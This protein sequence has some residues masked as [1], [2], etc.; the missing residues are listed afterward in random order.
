M[1]TI[2]SLRRHSYLKTIGTL[3]IA[4]SLIAG[5]VGCGDGVSTRYNLTM[6]ASPVD[7]GNATDETNGSPY[8]EGTC[9]RIKAVAAADYV[10]VKWTAPAGT[11]DDAN[12]EETTFTMPAESVTVTAN[13]VG[14]LDHTTFYMVD[15]ATAPDVGEEVLL[16]DHFGTFNV[17]VTS[18]II[19][20]NPAE[21]V[22][23]DVT[24]PISY[25]DHHFTVYYIDCE[26]EPLE[27]SV[28]VDNQFGTQELTLWGVPWLLAV[29][30]Q[31]AGHEPP[32]VLDHFLLYQVKE[33]DYVGEDVSLS[34][35][36]GSDP[37]VTVGSPYFFANPVRKTHDGEVT[38]IGNP[39]EHWVGYH[40]SDTNEFVEEVEVVNQFGEQT[41]DLEGPH[42][43]GVPSD[44]EIGS[45]LDHFKCYEVGEGAPVEQ[46]V[47]LEDQF[48]TF[49]A[50]V[51]DAY[52]F[53][54]PAEKVHGDVVTTI[55]NPDHH[56]TVYNLTCEGEPR[57]WF[58][59]VD[60]QF[61]T[62]PLT[63][64]GPVGLA[65]PTQKD[66]HEPPVGLDH[67]LLYEVVQGISLDV[68]VGLNDQ[69]GQEPEVSVY[70]PV[71]FANPVRKTH[72]G[73]ITE[74]ENPERHLVF[75][76]IDAGAFSMP[77][78]PV[79]NQFGEQT[80]DV[81]YP[82]RLAVPSVK[83][84]YMEAEP[85]PDVPLAYAAVLGDYNAQLTN[86]LRANEL[87]TDLRGW[88]VISDIGDYDVVVVN[89]PDDPGETTFQNLLN[90]ASANG[91]GIVFT[92]SYSTDDPW[93]ISL[94]ESYL[95]DPAAQYND[96]GEGAVYYKVME[97]H[98]IFN[99]WNIT[100]EITIITGGDADH[101]WF[102]GYSG[103]TTAQ[104]G[105]V[106]AGLRG[107][108]VAVSTYGGSTHVLLA[109][110]GPQSYTNENDWTDDGRT[111]FINAVLFAGGI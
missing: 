4:A 89:M 7:G 22:H 3:L 5:M 103:N 40:L 45:P 79:A 84:D 111:I 25:P 51:G 75:Y 12:N 73:D 10:F 57:E 64:S 48:G 109:S 14:R 98:P 31:K 24:T 104:V 43:L 30:T 42:W 86:L 78:L 19:F 2:L 21:K 33:S 82:I 36:F 107:D 16:E 50:A 62:R 68:V 67:F 54:N 17:T 80:L 77:D 87:S 83:I 38:E 65:V 72:G 106:Y 1:K 8:L 49:N 105:S 63:V 85:Q 60:N 20:G 101:N 18:A 6:A 44:A 34:D 99:G 91:V 26:E 74:I 23:N 56:L 81:E 90:A 69:F 96:W 15:E 13:F 41:L 46:D 108:A 100:D 58:V 94:L 88:D 66:G 102:S 39:D 11:F 70:K 110:L 47:Y 95:S 92:S 37:R 71:F 97:E 27:Q 32:V 53:G 93:G 59:T 9:I 35:Q 55:L 76:A 28:T 52:L 61:G 29:P